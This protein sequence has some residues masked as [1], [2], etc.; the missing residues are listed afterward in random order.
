MLVPMLDTI[1][2]MAADGGVARGGHRHGA[3]RAAQRP[4]AHPGQALRRPSS[5]SSRAAAR[6]CRRCDAGGRHRRREVSPRRARARTSRRAAA[7]ITVTLAPNPSHLEFVDPV[8]DGRARAKQTQRRGR[9]RTMTRRVAAGPASTA[10]R[11]S[12]GQGVVAETLNLA[13]LSGYQHRRHDPRHHQ[14]PDRLH[15]RPEDARSTRYA[16]RPR[17]GLRRPVFHVNADDPEACLSAIAAGHGVPAEFQQRRPHRPRGLSSPR[18]QRER[19]AGLHA[20]AAC[21]NASSRSRRCGS[22]MPASWWREGVLTQRRG[23]CAWR[24][25]RTSDWS[26]S[27]RRFKASTRPAHHARRAAASR[28]VAGQEV[29]TPR[30][31]AELLSALNDAAADRAR[32]TS[33]STRSWRSSSSV[34]RPAL[35]PDGGIDW[36]HAEALALATPAHRGRAAPLHRAGCRARHLQP[37]PRWCCTTSN[38][39]ATWCP[40]Q[41]LPGSM[42][43]FELLNS[44]LS[45]TGDARL[46][47]RLQRR[48]PRALVLWEAQFGDFING[49]QVIIDQFLVVGAF[50]V[51]PDDAAHAAAAAR[52]RGP[53]PGALERAARAVPAACA[54][55]NMRVANATTPAQ[56]F[57]LLRRQAKR[58]PP[59]A[60]R[61]H[62]AEEPAAA[63]AGRRRRST[64][65][66]EGRW[67]PVIDDASTEGRRDQVTRLVLCTGKVY[68][69][70]LAEA[71]KQERP[72]SRWCGWNS[73]IRSRGPR[74]GKCWRGTRISRNWCGHRRSRGTWARGLSRAEAARSAPGWRRLCT[75]L[76]GPTGRARPRAIQPPTR[77]SRTASSPS[78]WFAA[79]GDAGL[80]HTEGRSRGD[81]PSRFPLPA[82]RLA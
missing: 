48:R 34:A 43:P 54:E 61:D 19:R 13:A 77:W 69:D 24:A 66:A 57:H 35:G 16:V 32:R 18:P 40:L 7:T 70:L 22:S 27:S 60:A 5:R 31:A 46:R 2:E 15:H 6:R 68:Y 29:P 9:E 1:I 28:S 78:H 37:A 23:R 39:G 56:Y 52:L 10:T 67:Q 53:G 65:L 41:R 4:G 33:R 30:V 20:A 72:R 21:T 44:P 55:G 81:R 80:R 82:L 64:E 51:G 25:R 75:T 26:R 50:E 76:V 8:V 59:A 58:T 14:Q 42:A 49:A 3:P 45:E 47:V 63:P 79:R 36:A 71:S 62:D 73:S 38:T 17:Q 11:R 12:P 74:S